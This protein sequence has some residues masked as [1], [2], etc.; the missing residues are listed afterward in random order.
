MPAEGLF[1][2]LWLKL[3]QMRPGVGGSWSPRS[4]VAISKPI[5]TNAV[6]RLIGRHLSDLPL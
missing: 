3:S 4:G 6:N 5:V 2:K 1:G